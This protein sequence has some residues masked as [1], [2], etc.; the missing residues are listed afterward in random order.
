M[1]LQLVRA[2]RPKQWVKNTFCLAPLVFARQALVLE[3]VIDAM[4]VLVAF[5]L[6]A[7]A[8]YLVN[9]VVD[10]EGDRVHPVKRHRPI[11]SGKVSPAAALVAAIVLGGA[12]IAIG[13]SQ[14]SVVALVLGCYLVVNVGYT[15]VLK[16]LVLVDLFAIAIGFVLRVIAGAEAIEVTASNWILTCT[17]FI[18]LFMAASKRRSEVEQQG[19]NS[20]TRQVLS[21]YSVR[22]LDLIITMVGAGAILSYALYTMSPGT[23]EHL[24]TPNL[25]YTLPFVIFA[26]FRYMYLVSEKAKGESPFELL[27]GDA[28]MMLNIVGYGLAVLLIVYVT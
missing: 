20:G 7:S 3:A 21:R 8:V 28:P 6:L 16:R 12:A 22:Y 15:F 14:S 4:L 26:V 25:I 5:S 24:G 9:D 11:A 19:A 13:L 17:L 10:R 1:T 23:V 2:L 27:V 18:S